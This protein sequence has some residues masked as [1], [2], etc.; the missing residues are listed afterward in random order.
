MY[1]PYSTYCTKY[2]INKC[3]PTYIPIYVYKEKYIFMCIR[4]PI[5]KYMCME[6]SGV[7]TKI[8]IF[9]FIKSEFWSIKRLI[10]S[11]KNR[12]HFEVHW[13]LFHVCF[14]QAKCGALPTRLGARTFL[15]LSH[16]LGSHIL[17]KLFIRQRV[18]QKLVICYHNFPRELVR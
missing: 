9:N 5:Y 1:L 6:L 3:I 11:F 4:V 8:Y 12:L 17:Y 16:L 10:V 7:R 14:I 13:C 2:I 18:I 15:V